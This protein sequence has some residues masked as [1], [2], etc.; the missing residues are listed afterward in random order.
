M[1]DEV[2]EAKEHG[3][4]YRLMSEQNEVALK[5]LNTTC[6]DFKAQLREQIENLQV[7]WVYLCNLNVQIRSLLYRRGRRS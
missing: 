2:R 3:E 1:K 5:E 4:Q 7:G 6:D